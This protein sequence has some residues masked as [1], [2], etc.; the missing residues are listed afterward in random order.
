MR[1]ASTVMLAKQLIMELYTKVMSLV[2]KIRSDILHKLAPTKFY[3]Q[4][5]QIFKNV[6]M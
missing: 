4:I 3:V 5:I 2:P 1:G 6:E